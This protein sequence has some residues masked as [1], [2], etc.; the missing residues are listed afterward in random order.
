MQ[1]ANANPHKLFV[2]VRADHTLDGRIVPLLFRPEEGNPVHIDAILDTREAAARKAGSQ[3]V[4]YTIR[5]TQDNVERLCY[6]FHDRD[7]WFIE[8]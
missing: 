6:L 1:T 7:R 8:L 4:R 5:V 3:G 2:K